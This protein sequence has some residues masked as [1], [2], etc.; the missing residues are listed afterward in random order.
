MGYAFLVAGSDRATLV[1]CG[2]V[3]VRGSTSAAERLLAISE[4]LDALIRR[5]H[6]TALAVERLFFNKNART[7][8]RV[9]EARGVALL[10]GARAGLEI[11]E[12]TPQDV[13]ISVTGD[14]RGDK[15]AVQRMLP[16]LVAL[17]APIT[18]DNVADAVAI[19]LTHLQR[20][21]FAAAVAA[22]T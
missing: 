7:A 12:Y 11:A 20:A 6:P 19:A 15:K 4:A 13:K 9:S 1:E 21:Q 18:Q 14:G 3:G 16:R 17:D 22:A 5:H 2:L 8:M 10:C